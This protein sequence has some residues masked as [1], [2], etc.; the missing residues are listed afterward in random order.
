MIDMLNIVIKYIDFFFCHSLNSSRT[1][2]EMRATKHKNRKKTQKVFAS[3]IS[4]T[5]VLQ[6]QQPNDPFA[7]RI[8]DMLNSYEL[9]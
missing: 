8:I 7:V 6:Q 4:S 2:T 5:E 9:F 1:V 3:N